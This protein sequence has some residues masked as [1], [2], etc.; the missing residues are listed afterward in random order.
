MDK[1]HL[2]KDALK[3]RDE[4]LGSPGGENLLKCYACGAC[5]A[6]CPVREVDE[7]Y[8]PRRIIHMVLLGMREEVLRSDFIWLCSTCYT[9]SERCPQGVRLSTIMQ[10]LK[11]IAVREGIVPP[12]FQMQLKAIREQGK[13]YEIEDFDN[14]KRSRMGLPELEKKCPDV[15]I[16]MQ[17]GT[18]RDVK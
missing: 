17:G 3:F 2:N 10:V 8:N 11:N 16:L 4:I 9:C 1:I 14:K 6:S 5:A 12:S 15:D 18:L 13:L 7:R